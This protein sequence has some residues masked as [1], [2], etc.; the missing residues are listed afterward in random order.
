MKN[1][2]QP[3][4]AL[5][6]VAPAGGVVAGQ[7]IAIGDLVGAVTNSA[8]A[9][10]EFVLQTQG[11]AKF[12]G[13]AAALAIALGDTVYVTSAGAINKTASGNKKLG[14]AVAA[15]AADAT[16]VNVLISN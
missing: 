13:K 4:A 15:A 9:G 10:Q 7:A 6:L 14:V 16:D 11:V 8:A 3:G 1:M 12:P 5:T 2:F